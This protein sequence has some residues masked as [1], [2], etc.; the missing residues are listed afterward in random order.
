[1]NINILDDNKPTNEY[2]TALHINGFKSQINKH[3][4]VQI[5]NISCIDRIFLKSNNINTVLKTEKTDRFSTSVHTNVDKPNKLKSNSTITNVTKLNYENLE[6]EIQI[7]IYSNNSDNIADSVKTFTTT[8]TEYIRDY[9][10]TFMISRKKQPL[11]NGQPHAQSISLG[12]KTVGLPNKL[13]NRL[14]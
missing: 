6:Q 2:L 9:A 13:N 3:N 5:E 4:T 8:L 11:K 7:S 1:M 10:Y 12:R 14:I